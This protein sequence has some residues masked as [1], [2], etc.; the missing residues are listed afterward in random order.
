MYLW[1]IWARAVKKIP[2]PSYRPFAVT[3]MEPI[4]NSV[5]LSAMEHVLNRKLLA[6]LKKLLINQQ[7]VVTS[8]ISHEHT[9]K[10]HNDKA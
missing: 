5:G 9:T 1:K 4:V 10:F 3:A 6:L 7:T 8:V 2:Q